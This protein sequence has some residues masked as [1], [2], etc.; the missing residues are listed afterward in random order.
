MKLT[1]K[2]WKEHGTKLYGDD[3]K[4]WKFQC[5]SCD[6]ITKVLE[7]KAVGGEPN[8]AYQNCIGRFA[9]GR[10]GK[11]KCDWAAYGLFSGPNFVIA[12]DGKEIPVFPFG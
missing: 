9:G 4:E 8:D 1:E 3:F 5:P 12:E 2:E 10:K 7:F 6:R 11:Y